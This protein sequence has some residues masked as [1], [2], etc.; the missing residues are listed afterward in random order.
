MNTPL[1]QSFVRELTLRGFTD[2]TVES[3]VYWVFDLAR[4]YHRSPDQISDDE[5]KGYLFHLH[6]ERELRSSSIYQ[7]VHALRSFYTLTLHRPAEPLK[8]VLIAPKPETRRPEVF[9][10][11]EVE[12]LL[13]V[14]V[15]NLRD[16][17]FLATVYAA[18]LRLNEAC[19]LRIQDLSRDRPQI[20][21]EQGKGRK[22]RY[23]IFSPH[24]RELLREYWLQERPQVW[25]FPSRRHPQE[26]L[27][28][29][30]GQR[31][32]YRAVRRAG[33]SNK[34]GLHCLRH[35]FATHLLESGVEV[36][37]V[38]R[39]LGHRSLKT[40]ARYLQVRLERLEQVK[41]PLDLLDLKTISTH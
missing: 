6:A 10:I 40:T 18:G 38:Q 19:H 20:R 27:P 22:D 2:R 1:R 14:G 25:L 17:A 29:G 34:G 12:R 36:T 24:L 15:P 28:D 32:Y 7:A 30:T 21:V 37:L 13:T 9:S 35:S 5:L 33:L 11:Q 26:P 39:L 16:R 4:Y 3:Y 23:T 8:T 31:L 41:S